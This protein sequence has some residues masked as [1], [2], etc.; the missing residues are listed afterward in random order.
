M[1][2]AV[3]TVSL[4]AIDNLI[5]KLKLVI[6]GRAP[7][8]L[9]DSYHEE[10][11]FAAD[12]NLLIST[13]STDFITPKSATARL[14]RDAVLELAHDEDFA[15]PPVNSGR[16]SR[17]TPYLQ[18]S[19]NTTGDASFAG[20]MKPGTNFTDAPVQDRA[21]RDGWL[22]NHLGQDF[23][24]LCFGPASQRTVAL[25]N[26]VSARVIEVGRDL[27]DTQG[28]LARRCDARPGTVYLLRPDQHVAA[29]WRAFDATRIRAAM[30]TCL[31]C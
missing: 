5:W 8:A 29:R 14:L 21:G 6:D 11:A 30:S 16:L 28:L 18:S 4:P 13:R 20:L 3:F 22:L 7:L 23:I 12:D 17:P 10:R 24:V 2:S 15:R 26:G 9:V 31:S 1:T 19:L 25:D 27:L